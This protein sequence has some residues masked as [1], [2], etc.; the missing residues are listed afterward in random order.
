MWRYLLGTPSF[1]GETVNVRYHIRHATKRSRALCHAPVTAAFPNV[2]LSAYAVM[3]L[4]CPFDFCETCWLAAPIKLKRRV[5]VRRL[6]VEESSVNLFLFLPPMARSTE[7]S[8]RDLTEKPDWD[9]I[10]A[11][12][13]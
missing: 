10:L 2:F 9:K 11:E 13:V 1:C 3:E 12:G 5:P 4:G 8:L 7:S 6:G